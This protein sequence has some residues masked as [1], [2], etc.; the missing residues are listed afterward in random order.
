MRSCKIGRQRRLVSPDKWLPARQL[1]SLYHSDL[2]TCWVTPCGTNMYPRRVWHHPGVPRV[3]PVAPVSS[4]GPP[5]LP[6]VCPY[7]KKSLSFVNLQIYSSNRIWVYSS[8]VYVCVHLWLY[9]NTPKT[10]GALWEKH[11]RSW[12]TARRL[13]S[14]SCLLFWPQMKVNSSHDENS[15]C[16]PSCELII[17][18]TEKVP[19]KS[20]K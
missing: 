17:R 1:W 7:I 19:W 16:F 12:G 6:P 18:S 20:Q 3:S 13:R 11:V 8:T 14:H 2:A 5:A 4:R 10:I 15:N 9:N